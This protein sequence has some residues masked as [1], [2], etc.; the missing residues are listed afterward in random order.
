VQ[1]KVIT[2]SFF[3]HFRKPKNMVPRLQIATRNHSVVFY[4]PYQLSTLI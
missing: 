3:S 2:A 4:C 1:K